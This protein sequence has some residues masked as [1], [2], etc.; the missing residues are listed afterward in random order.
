MSKVKKVSVWL[1]AA[2]LVLIII[3]TAAFFIAS[4]LIQKDS[5]KDKIHGLIAD[6][7]GGDIDYETMT[8]HFFHRPHVLIKNTELSIPDKFEGT[9]DTVIVYPKILP[10]LYG[11]VEVSELKFLRP[12]MT[13]MIPEKSKEEE[14]IDGHEP[15]SYEEQREQLVKILDY[16]NSKWKGFN[17][18]IDYANLTIK[19]SDENFLEFNNLNAVIAYPNN[20]LNY[21]IRANSNISQTIALK[22]VINTKSYDANGDITLTRF[23]PHMLLNYLSSDNKLVTKSNIDIDVSY[24]T[25]SLEDLSGNV[26]VSNSELTLS[27]GDQEFEIKGNKID[28]DV[29]LDEDKTLITLNSV[30]MAYPDI[31]ASGQHRIDKKENKVN[32]NLNGNNID[33]ESSRNAVLFMAGGDRIVDLIFNIVRGGTIPNISLTASGEDFR[34]LWRKGNFVLKA[35]LIDGNIFIP[36]G[37]F[38]L[39]DVSGDALIADGKLTGTDL[40]AKSGTAVG[41]D[42]TF[43]IGIEGPIGPLHLDIMIDSDASEIPPIIKKFVD[44]EGFLH[45]LSM[46]KNLQ[47]TAQGKL[48]IGDQKKSPKTNVYVSE[49]DITADY[50]RVPLPVNVKGSNFNYNHKSIDF[51]GLKVKIGEF[52]SPETT[53]SYHWESDKILALS[54][55]NTKVDLAIIFPW[56]TSFNTLKDDLR[57]IESIKGSAFFSFLNFKGPVNDS[58]KWEIGAEGNINTVELGLQGLDTDMTISEAQI[59]TTTQ[60]LAI[61]E[62]TVD[63]KDSKMTVGAVLTNY[64]TDWLKLQMDFYGNMLA[65]EAKVFSDY[66][67]VPTQLN[68]NSPVEIAESNIVL[69]KKPA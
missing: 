15:F 46:I 5:V 62:T 61:T 4:N 45:E 11:N 56:L 69:K 52:S 18:R 22:G 19:K 36:Y 38:D 6:K 13:L 12:K 21:R 40:K 26:V 32:L 28:T 31:K 29:V 33:V 59:K 34:D 23:K 14:Q 43:I 48:K 27:K 68:F 3:V 2:A 51:E 47:G 9:F 41:H 49:L 64:L 50:E 1:S 30:D 25:K 35:N 65:E 55:K 8:L 58:E 54:S 63:I 20:S 37:D 67:N 53:G 66:F 60:E 17:A 24:K 7:V 44:D 16:L 42:G 10:L 57:H 39:T